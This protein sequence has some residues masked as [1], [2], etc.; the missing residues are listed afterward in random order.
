MR[1]SSNLNTRP[2][3]RLTTHLLP[4]EGVAD[5]ARTAGV[6]V[7]LLGELYGVLQRDDCPLQDDGLIDFIE[8]VSERVLDWSSEQGISLPVG[9]QEPERSDAS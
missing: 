1:S 5:P 8:E 4:D 7:A 2:L 6:V 9:P 3:N